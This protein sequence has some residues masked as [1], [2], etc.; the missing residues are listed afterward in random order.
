MFWIPDLS[1]QNNISHICHY[2]IKITPFY[3]SA[4]NYVRLF[5]LN[6]P[7]CPYYPHLLSLHSPSSLFPLLSLC[8]MLPPCSSSTLLA[9][10]PPSLPPC[11]LPP[12]LPP[13]RKR[14]LSHVRDLAQPPDPGPSLWTTG[15]PP[16]IG[17]SHACVTYPN[18]G[19]RRQ[20]TNLTRVVPA[21]VAMAG[22]EI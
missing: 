15:A 8:A 11:P 6:F 12:S 22:D 13:C 21:M 16:W 1:L 10:S 3:A 2:K 20:S 7:K 18:I 17:S 9:L 19:L 14:R 4:I 5:P